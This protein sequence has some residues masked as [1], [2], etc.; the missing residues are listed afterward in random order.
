MDATS[1]GGNHKERLTRRVKTLIALIA[2][3]IASTSKVLAHQS[4]PMTTEK[5]QL[6]HPKQ[7]APAKAVR[8]AV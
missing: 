7:R 6:A 4:M 8:F 1:P 5:R 2:N 3:G